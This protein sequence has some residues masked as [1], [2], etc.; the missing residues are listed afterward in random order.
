MLLE[1]SE[2]MEL[3]QRCSRVMSSSPRTHI[4]VSS[5]APPTAASVASWMS[6]ASG[7]LAPPFVH[8]SWIG[9]A[10][11]CRLRTAT[12]SLTTRDRSLCAAPSGVGSVMTRVD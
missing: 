10:A 9:T 5:S 4:V 1:P 8:K 12:V 3:E 7:G 6:L 11:P 2:H